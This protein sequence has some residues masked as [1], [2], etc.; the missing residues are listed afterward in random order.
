M[1]VRTIC[2][3]NCGDSVHSHSPGEVE[4]QYCDHM[5][6]QRHGYNLDLFSYVKIFVVE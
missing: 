6:K 4:L 5:Y 2:D 1:Q 3:E